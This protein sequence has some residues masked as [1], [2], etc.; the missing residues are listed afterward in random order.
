ML[1][2]TLEVRFKGGSESNLVTEADHR[3][4]SHILAGLQKR[5]P[6]HSV[7]CEESGDRAGD[8]AFKWI[9]DPL[10]GTTNFAHG[11]PNFAVSI[12]LEHAGEVVVGVVYNPVLDEM[13]AAARDRPTTLNGR[14]IRVS[15]AGR[16]AEG[17]LATG[18]P[19]EVHRQPV[20]L[21]HFIAFLGRAQAIRR[22]GSA[23][24]D[25]CSVA[26]GRFDGFWEPRLAPWDVA[27][28]ALIVRQAG[29]QLS[30]F[31]G[32]PFSIYV[33]EI[34]ASNGHIHSA[35]VEVLMGVGL[36]SKG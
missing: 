9:V 21:D 22:P 17:L 25:L 27:A 28:G 18:F 31:T 11:Y 33:P 4:E 16:L 23:S 14:P 26:A 12:A 35:M 2:K 36:N 32:G 8:P 30:N 5:H 34:V 1:G 10:D 13:F 7:L 20:N 15:A 24:L 6:D 3:S 29:G 19:P